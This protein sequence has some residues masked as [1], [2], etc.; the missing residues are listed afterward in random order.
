MDAWFIGGGANQSAEVARAVPY[1]A[2]G[3]TEGITEP[4]DLRVEALPVPGAMIRVL[5][6]ACTIR[7]R[8][9][10]GDRQSY[11]GLSLQELDVPVAAT[12]SS[13]GRSDLV[14]IRVED[15]FVKGEPWQ[16]P[17][18]PE[19]ATYIFPRVIPNVPA[20]TTRLQDVP[21][22]ADETAITLARIDIP[23]STATITWELI[24][25]LRQVAQPK[26]KDEVYARP[27]VLEDDEA[28]V[29]LTVSNANGGEYFPGGNGSPNL[30]TFPV[31]EWASSA[32]IDAQWM[33]VA[34]AAGQDPYGLRWIEFGDEYREHTWP[35][36]Q[37]YEFSTEKFAFNAENSN[38]KRRA[39]WRVVDR[40]AIPA[41]LRGKTIKFCFKA[42]LTSSDAGVSMDYQGGLSLRVTF[43]QVAS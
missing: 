11:I 20:G 3:A 6:G 32:V 8:S 34:Y 37:Q 31:P 36:K 43:E 26:Q 23:A 21:G 18:D 30:V 13:G 29:N 22:H 1:I 7:S 40:V 27:R 5:P 41:K 39:D 16:E 24:T 19:N 4:E 2:T 35:N 25:D 33:S 14:V 38:D 42:G 28:G 9:E 12:G 17:A 15:P 10:N